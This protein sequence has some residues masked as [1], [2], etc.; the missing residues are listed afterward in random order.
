MGFFLEPRLNSL[1]DSSGVYLSIP[2]TWDFSLNQ[3]QAKKTM[4]P[5]ALLSIPSTWDFSLNLW[6]KCLYRLL[7]LL[8]SIPSTWDFSLNQKRYWQ[9]R[10]ASKNFQFPLHG[11]F[12]WTRP[13][14]WLLF[15]DGGFSLS[16]SLRCLRL[17]VNCV[18]V[19]KDNRN[20]ILVVLYS[21]IIFLIHLIL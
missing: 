6:G 3:D 12:P 11:I 8:L 9:L 15:V 20:S 7:C 1:K 18:F 17:S 21:Y 13:L 14:I 5:K 16:W 10:K 2:S 19:Y 4:C